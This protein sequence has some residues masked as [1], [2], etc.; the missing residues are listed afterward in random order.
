[1]NTL[2]A[3]GGMNYEDIHVKL[4]SGKASG[5]SAG[6]LF[7]DEAPEEKRHRIREEEAYRPQIA[8]IREAADLLLKEE[9]PELTYSL[10]RLFADK[11]TRSEYERVY[12]L[13]RKRLTTFA[14]MAWL[15]PENSA[16]TEA[17]CNAVWSLCDEYTWC[18]PAHILRGPEMSTAVDISLAADP[19]ESTGYTV[20]LFAAETAFALSEILALT[21]DSLPALLQRRIREEVIR[22]V[23]RPFVQGGPFDWET[24]THNW[25]SVCAGSIGAAA[26]YL[27]ADTEELSG[28]LQ[29]VL[30]AM[31]SYLRGFEE[32]GACTEGYLYWQ[33]GFGY[34]V[35]FADLLSQRTDGALNL[36]ASNKVREIALFQQKCFLDK[37]KVVNFSDSLPEAGIFMGLSHYLKGLYADVEAPEAALRAGY[38]EDHCSRWAPAVRNLL[39]FR[40]EEQGVPWGSASYYLKDAQ[41]LVSRHLTPQGR[42]M[43]AA[44]GGHNAEPHNHNDIGHFIL[45]A[46]GVTLL[47]DLG[48]GQ[49]TRSYFGPQRYEILCNGSLGHSV[50]VINGRGQREGADAKAKVLETNRSGD[51]EV[52]ALELASAYE[53]AVSLQSLE[54]RFMWLKSELPQL[55]LEDKF[56]FADAPES[57]SERLMSWLK[58]VLAGD[59]RLVMD[60]GAVRLYIEYDRNSLDWRTEEL[61]HVDHFGKPVPCYAVDFIV[62]Q[63]AVT[64]TVKLKLTFQ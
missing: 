36:F 56:V 37:R 59:G 4:M 53:A 9:T 22:R 49:Y 13:R 55:V 24:A 3:A 31:D 54:R 21:A 23:L 16:Y 41:W 57:V 46:E 26:I 28:V 63:P 50:P 7:A 52:Y 51:R 17:L 14:L 40:P 6:Y 8:E 2:H 30:P 29:R 38:S 33:Y 10:F 47:A 18:L 61:L 60:G 64:Q 44:K 11:G 48:S 15:E 42:Y 58:P 19:G 32:D 39:W 27:L 5:N 43:F 34:Y 12:F 35:Y 25:A 62:K 1:M 20:D 45:C